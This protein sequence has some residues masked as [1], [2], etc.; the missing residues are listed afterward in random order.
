MRFISRF[1]AVCFVVNCF[2]LAA[3][4]HAQDELRAAWAISNYD[5]TVPG[6]GGERALNARA[7]ITARNVGRGAG[8][9]LTL[10]INSTAEIKSVTIGS[11]TATYQSRPE[12]RGASQRIASQRVTISLPAPVAP[13]QNAVA[14]I[15]YRLPVDENTGVAALSPVGSQ[16]LPQSLWF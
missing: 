8:S 11:A 5:I 7:T 6:W 13:N 2:A 9:T 16:F 1:L 10:R 4:I 3:T 12:S 14:I 15:E